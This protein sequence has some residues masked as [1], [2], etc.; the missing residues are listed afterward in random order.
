MNYT[1]K[2]NSRYT[3]SHYSYNLS[4][5]ENLASLF[6]CKNLFKDIESEYFFPMQTKK[7]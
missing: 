7:A 3:Q 5:D 1:I 2:E 6:A 4:S